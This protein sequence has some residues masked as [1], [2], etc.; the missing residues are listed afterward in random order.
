MKRKAWAVMWAAY[1]ASVAV[2]LN[3]FKVPPVMQ[4]LLDELHVDM[5]TGGWFMSVFAVAAVILA[6][7]AAVL[8]SRLGPKLSGLV[9]LGCTIL[10]CVIGALAQGSAVM[11]AGRLIEGIGL[12]LIGVVAPAVIS[13]WFE[14]QE[15]GLPMGIWA[16]W[17][18]VGSFIMFNLANPLQNAFG[19]PGIWWFG[20]IF[21]LI[22]FLVYGAVVT[23]PKKEEGP[24]QGPSDE[25]QVSLTQ[26]FSSVN[27][28][29]LAVAF[30][31][32]NFGFIGYNTWA[33]SFLSQVHG[34]EPS[35][36]SFYASL[37]LLAVIPANVLAGWV[38]DRTKNRKVVLAVA[39]ALAGIILAWCFR[40]GSV[41]IVALYMIG[42]GLVAG[43][44]PTCIF[45]LAPDTMPRPEL[46]GLA[47]GIVNLG[48]NLGM[49]IAPPLI[50]MAVAGGSWSSGT[51]P[52]IIAV[53]VALIATLAVR[54]QGQEART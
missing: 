38:L 6:I 13:I 51:Y 23:M 32:F 35:V 41:S 21:A 46:A 4:V 49:L 17:L 12:G 44:I 42:L 5:A 33:P 40:L 11:L 37:M 14:P 2:S 9:A 20:A 16:S 26:G 27:A 15:R 36:A 47:L 19:W 54:L 8:L 3:Q 30:G 7:P 22:A 50:G 48:Q 29:L 28:W 34:V 43:F 25:P 18:P 10:G 1:L 31:G 39:L 45:T 53:V 52:V 24:Q